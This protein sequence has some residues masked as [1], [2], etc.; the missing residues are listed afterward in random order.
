MRDP[1]AASASVP[2]RLAVRGGG[3]GGS[4]LTVAAGSAVSP[5]HGTLSCLP[6]DTADRAAVGRW[7]E[8]LVYNYLL[9]TLPPERAVTWL[10][11]TEETRAPYDLTI[12][13]RGKSA[14]RGGGGTSSSAVSVFI[15]VKTTRYR[16]SNVFDLSYFEWEFMSHEPPVRYHIY[17]VTGAGDPA[18]ARI[19]IIEDPVQA[20]KDES[21]RLCMAI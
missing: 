16:E 19:T 6:L 13:E 4:T 8:A 17:H 2:S 15:E 10:N 18:G 21:S 7:G 9:A 11:R 20:M 12:C 14:H 1:S 3:G 5:W